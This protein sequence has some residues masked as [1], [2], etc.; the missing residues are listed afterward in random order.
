MNI[1]SNKGIIKISRKLLDE[2]VEKFDE[3][4]PLFAD[5]VPVKVDYDFLTDALSICGY[6]K[7]F[8]PLFEGEAIP[9]YEA[10]ISTV[11][12]MVS[13]TA[14]RFVEVPVYR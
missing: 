9:V 2:Y 14:T 7:Q 11:T 5:F 8:R 13:T 12:N 10:R 4:N 6:S 3:A 1:Q